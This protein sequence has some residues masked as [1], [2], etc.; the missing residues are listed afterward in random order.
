M[1]MM[2]HLLKTDT[3]TGLL[4]QTIGYTYDNDFRLASMTYGGASQALT[5]DDDGLLTGAGAFTIT[6]N[7]QNGLPVGITDGTC[8]HFP[9]LQRI[10][11]VGR[12]HL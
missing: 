7:A 2:G 4:N 6:R 5:Y 9:D 11:G 3:R 10:W 12:G 8:H 1:A